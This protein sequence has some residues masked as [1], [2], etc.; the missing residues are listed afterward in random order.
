[1]MMRMI[2]RCPRL[3]DLKSWAQDRQRY[4]RQ[5]VANKGRQSHRH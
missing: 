5:T 3:R 1:M 2:S 4:L